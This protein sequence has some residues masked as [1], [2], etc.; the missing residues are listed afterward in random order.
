[1]QNEYTIYIHI[2]YDYYY[3]YLLC[4]YFA[5]HYFIALQQLAHMVFIAL[6]K[7]HSKLQKYCLLSY[8]EHNSLLFSPAFIF[9]PYLKTL[10]L[11]CTIKVGP[12][13][14]TMA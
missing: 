8:V 1:M 11:T 10:L 14:V 13:S 12:L 9:I 7:S 3:D 2:Y 6:V 4:I 5:L